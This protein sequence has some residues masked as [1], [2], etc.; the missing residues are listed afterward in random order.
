VAGL[1]S[2]NAKSPLVRIH[3]LRVRTIDPVLLG[4]RQGRL[5]AV[6][7]V[8]AEPEL[9]ANWK[10]SGAVFGP[11]LQPPSAQWSDRNT[12][13]VVGEDALAGRA[14]NSGRTVSCRMR[15][16]PLAR[17]VERIETAPSRRPRRRRATGAVEPTK[18]FALDGDGFGF[19]AL[20]FGAENCRPVLPPRL[21]P[22]SPTSS[23][24]L[25]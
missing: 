1:P 7:F 21:M 14:R 20:G 3:K 23:K 4:G 25:A 18:T 13:D 11:M 5:A 12:I 2:R 24:R 8:L 16:G 6:R 10:V 17:Q 22:R 15:Q 9:R 19:E